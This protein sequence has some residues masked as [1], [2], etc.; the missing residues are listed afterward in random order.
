MILRVLALP[1]IAL[2]RIYQW[3]ISPL[4]GPR[5]RFTPSCSRYA[6]EALQKHG[7][8]KGIWLSGESPAVIPGAGMGPTRFREL[9]RDLFRPGSV[10][11]SEAVPT[12]YLFQ[13]GDILPL[14]RDG[15]EFIN[16]RH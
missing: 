3:G 5:C 8:I 13:L 1:L 11:G 9:F 12:P 2:I 6:V 16:F 15:I 10:S 4:L 14:F 7:L